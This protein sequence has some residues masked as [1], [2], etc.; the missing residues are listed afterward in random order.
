MFKFYRKGSAFVLASA[1]VALSTG[2]TPATAYAKQAI[3]NDMS[4]CYSTSGPAILIE[5]RGFEKTDGRIRVQ[6][7]RATKDEW[8]EKGR[9]L[10]RIET[11]VKPANGVMRFC[12][13]VPSAGSYGIAVRHDTNNNGKTDIWKDGGGF[14]NNPKANLFNLGKPSVGKVAVS[15]GSRPTSIAIQLQ[16]M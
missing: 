3:S 13:P 14:S 15:V 12:M 1:C 9:W 16:Y 2:S 10:N 5:I 4:R 11:D 7:Y 8:L 6:S